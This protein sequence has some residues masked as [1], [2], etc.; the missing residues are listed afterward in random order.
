MCGA[1]LA[2]L[3]RIVHKAGD[4]PTAQAGSSQGNSMSVDP[5]FIAPEACS[6]KGTA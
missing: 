4:N 6:V 2:I 1:S 3:T 5:T